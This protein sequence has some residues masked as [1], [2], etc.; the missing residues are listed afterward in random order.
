MSEP[1]TFSPDE[2]DP[3]HMHREGQDAAGNNGGNQV[4][5]TV[6]FTDIENSVSL[7]GMLGQ[8]R[9]AEVLARHG[10]LFREAL[11]KTRAEA[12]ENTGD[13][14]MAR[15]EEATDAVGVAL[16]FQW[17]L[18]REKWQMEHA[19]R[20]RVGI[21]RGEMLLISGEEREMPKAVGVAVSMAARVMGMAD[22]GQMLL[23]R[24]VFDEARQSITAVPEVPGKEQATLG[25]EA[26]GAYFLKGVEG[27]QEV[28]EVGERGYAPFR[29][30]RDGANAERSRSSE[31]KTTLGWR[32]AAEMEVPKRP[33]WRLVRKLGYGGFG[34]VWLAE[35]RAK[36]E[37]RVFKFCFDVVKLR[38]F[39]RELKLFQFIRNSLGPR[40][41]IATLYDVQLESSPY[42]LESAYCN[43][44]TL[45]EW[46]TRKSRDGEVPLT[47]RLAIMATVARALAA[48][49]SVGIIHKDV[50]PSNI[51]IDELADGMVRPQ[52]ADFGIGEL[53]NRAAME[54]TNPH[55]T[56]IWA[57]TLEQMHSGT[58]MYCP[59]EYIG[60]S[61]A[62]VLGDIYSFGV[63]LYQV[64][65]LD[66]H[67]LIVGDGWR[68]DVPDELL[69][70]DIAACVDVRPELRLSSAKLV[71]ERLETLEQRREALAARDA[72]A[73]RE[74][75]LIAK[76]RAQR[77]KVRLAVVS[78]SIAA[79]LI[80]A[81][82]AL[83]IVLDESRNAE[84][85]HSGELAR[86][87][88]I[89]LEQRYR[90]DMI[91][92]ITNIQKWR[93][94]A[95]RKT[96]AGYNR[97]AAG[98]N[99]YGWELQF[100]TD[101][102]NPP[103]IS[104]RV[105]AQP[106]RA[107]AVSSDEKSAAMADADGV[108]SIRSCDTL[109]NMESWT[110]GP[111]RSLAWK[112]EVLA[113]GLETG[114]VVLRNVA[115]KQDRKR[116]KAHE[117]AVTALAWNPQRDELITGGTD[118]LIATWQS[119]GTGLNQ[120]SAQS[121]VLALDW[122]QEGRQ[123]AVIL[124]NPA[125]L[126][127]GVP[128]KL[129][130][131]YAMYTAESAVAWRPGENEVAVSMKDMA[132][133]SF[134]PLSGLDSFHIKGPFSPGASAF[135][136]APDGMRIAVGGIDGKIIVAT[137]NAPT[138][139][140]TV[141]YGHEHRI[142]A[143]RWLSRGRLLSV[144]E[145]GT[146]RAW[147]DLQRPPHVL[148]TEFFAP[149]ADAQWHPQDGRLAVLLAGEQVQVLDA[150]RQMKWTRP[151]PLPSHGHLPFAGGRLAWS[152]DGNWLA[153]ACPGRGLVAWHMDRDERFC[154]GDSR[155]VTDA[156]LNKAMDVHWLDDS[157]TLLVHT[158]QGWWR[159]SLSG[160]AP[161]RIADANTVWI[162]D[163][164]G[165][166]LGRLS[167]YEGTTYFTLENAGA[168]PSPPIELPKD[169]GRIHACALNPKRTRLAVASETG[170]FLWF[171]TRGGGFTRPEMQ[172][173][174]SAQAI[175][176]HPDGSRL[177]TAS[178]DGTCRVFDAAQGAQTWMVEH[179][180]LHEIVAA[181]WNFD[182]QSLMLASAQSHAVQ[183]YEAS[184]SS[185][186][187]PAARAAN[188]LAAIDDH[189]DEESS[190]RAFADELDHNQDERAGVL[191][192]AA[193]LGGQARFAPLAADRLADATPTKTWRNIELPLAVQI[194]QAC[195][196]ERWEEVVALSSGR[197]NTSAAPWFDLARAEGL[198][199][200]GRQKESEAANLEAWQ[201]LRRLHGVADPAV[202][203]PQPTG[204][205]SSI[206][207]TPYAT[208]RP[209]DDWAMEDEMGSENNNLPTLPAVL[210]P[211]PDGVQFRCGEFILLGGRNFR[212]TGGCMLPRG[213]D[214]IPLNAASKQIA[215][216]IAACNAPQTPEYQDTCIGSI[217]LLRSNGV[218]V[219]IPLVF[220]QNIWRWW[221]PE[222]PQ[223]TDVP[224]AA[225]VWTG[226]N[227]RAH[228]FHF[229]LALYRLNWTA[230][231]D[232]SSV[233]AISIVSAMRQPAP[234]LMSVD[235]RP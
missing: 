79:V 219:R 12:I 76:V 18:R 131:S 152:P 113:V 114:E 143:L 34:E 151:M 127:A 111:V 222:D 73:R 231:A 23:T 230:A 125:R 123:L 110:A 27:A 145:D 65:V 149:L 5:Q 228:N 209:K 136:W 169:I 115:M 221:M 194:A 80:A 215:C 141:L 177:V 36:N 83:V 211:Q 75:D 193:K 106:L 214:W 139:K 119:D 13:G 164:G 28:F 72:A 25:W 213:T 107:L 160:E 118:K 84:I 190:W 235:A 54:G 132:M 116:W 46:L 220:G 3:T 68:R 9:W 195:A 21:H 183:I 108:I 204:G 32:P 88:E 121:P 86:Q 112:G 94:E 15:F 40:T 1:P 173:S 176:W 91:A 61:Q 96:V 82:A 202:I 104:E 30:P 198:A 135:A 57:F 77:K 66:F 126:L 78:T 48:A 56:E 133:C 201:E 224:E 175:A 90:V 35:H 41:D 187:S 210:D 50:K 100:A 199:Q 168:D 144:G 225:I 130:H 58:Q 154:P 63:V 150:A 155:Q 33:G 67:R 137:K 49:H 53:A 22:G 179:Q 87:R 128:G 229:K 217:Y 95:S 70:G 140:S 55:N 81:L 93:G 105:S 178:S 42:F 16:R 212:V 124:G 69:A 180:L 52:L 10:H 99:R 157:L 158:D 98:R 185:D 146:V 47:Q 192:A 205:S 166:S 17:L 2:S 226:A 117:G 92:A 8:H 29:R 182:G 147:D 120:F 203:P 109:E 102:L 216:V 162:G 134:D 232:E 208:A 24:E 191:L 6:M 51:F 206:D 233:V 207:L 101:V 89:E 184:S 163:L 171:D 38:S 74:Q 223:A 129:E 44:G 59:P 218:A 138:E 122:N 188:V 62:S 11:G 39:Q 189:P 14:F 196:L 181:G 26:H 148:T 159:V 167:M 186:H 60:S 234:L 197:T 7:T 4:C 85:K 103:H 200:L 161:I 153:A 71:A 20:V 37:K 165:G 45:D 156:H 64:V 19:L 172:H 31:E 227:R 174:S 170:G 142:T 43:G 97:A